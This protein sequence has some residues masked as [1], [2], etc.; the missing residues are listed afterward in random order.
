LLASLHAIVQDAAEPRVL[1][2]DVALTPD[3]WDECSTVLPEGRVA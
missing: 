3:G 2:D 1:G